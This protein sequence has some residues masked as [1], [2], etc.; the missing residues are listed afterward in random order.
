MR[1]SSK[2]AT[3]NSFERQQYDQISAN[4]IKEYIQGAWTD[5]TQFWKPWFRTT[6]GFRLDYVHGSVNSEAN[7]LLALGSFPPVPGATPF[8]LG[9]FNNGE[10]GRF[11]TSPKFGAV[12]G[13]FYNSELFLNFGEGLRA[14]DMR[15]ATNHYATDGTQY[16]YIPNVQLLTKTRGAETGIRTKP[17]EGLDTSLTFFWQDLD[18]EQQFNADTAMSTYGRPGRR[19]GFEWT[20]RYEANSWMHFDA[21]VTA[22]HARFRG[23]DTIQA[24]NYANYLAG[25]PGSDGGLWPLGLPGLSP[26]NYLSLAPVWVSTWDIELGEKKGWFGALTGRYFG[27]RPLTEDGQVESHATFTV[28]ARLGYRFDNGLRVQFDAFNILDSRSDMIDYQANVWGRQNFA[29]WPGYGTLGPSA[30]GISER[31]FKPIDPPAVRLTVSGPLTFVDNA[32]IAA[33]Y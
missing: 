12:V 20:G 28:N 33:K 31:V 18:A 19:Y 13:P 26:G 30:Y 17:I 8:Y 27:A 23:F 7:P 11:F 1:I 16:T 21:D 22:T 25:G 24:A 14:E 2:T 32:P 6:E 29:I 5:T 15:G 4:A 3:G 10:L 9:T